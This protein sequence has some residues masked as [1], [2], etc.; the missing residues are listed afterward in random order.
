MSFRCPYLEE[1]EDALPSCTAISF[2]T[3][4]EGLEV[5]QPGNVG[6]HKHNG[7]TAQVCTVSKMPEHQKCCHDRYVDLSNIRAQNSQ[8]SPE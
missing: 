4:I 2:V 1:S 7:V 8:A 5:R 6:S 3:T